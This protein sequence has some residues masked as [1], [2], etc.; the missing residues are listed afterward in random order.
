[1]DLLAASS[2][3]KFIGLI[4][5]ISPLINNSQSAP[6]LEFFQNGSSELLRV[7][8]ERS[9]FSIGRCE[10]S[11][12]RIDSVEVSREHAQIY[13]RGNIWSIRD[14]GST[15]GTQV[16]GKPVSESFLSAGDILTIAET[17]LTFVASS[18]TPFQRMA[19]QPIQPRES[20]KPPALLP[21]EIAHMR[22][23]SEAILWQAIPLQLSTAVVIDSGDQEAAF[24]HFTNATNNSDPEFSALRSA[25]KRYLQLARR[26][27]IELAQ[28]DAAASRIFLAADIA[29]FDAPRQLFGELDQLRDLLP[30]E[31]ELGVAISLPKIFDPSELDNAC[32]EVRNAELLLGLVN[33]QGSN[34][35]VLEL[36]AN[37]PDYLV[38]S[39][40]MLAGVAANSQPLRRLELVLTSCRQLGIKAVLPPCPCQK[41]IAQCRQLGYEFAM[42]SGTPLEKT[43]ALKSLAFAG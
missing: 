22:A 41:T 2:V 4:V 1:M 19:T 36:S 35:Q 24:A 14:L 3:I 6:R 13:R 40:K 28:A 23:L 21:S 43:G 31:T 10:T 17:E 20:S 18:A 15:N 27:A 26:R 5:L 12:L 25:G 29:E 30:L 8:I 33:F 11:D 7:T 39:D 37:A 9:P 16:N 32:R 42:P 34:S 38:L